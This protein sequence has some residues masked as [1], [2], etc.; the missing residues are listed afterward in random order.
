MRRRGWFATIVAAVGLV[1][2]GS[3]IGVDDFTGDDPAARLPETDGDTTSGGEG[4]GG[5]APGGTGGSAT[6]PELGWGRVI[7]GAGDDA[8][9]VAVSQG[10]DHWFAGYIDG[11]V[12]FGAG[13]VGAAGRQLF[14]AAVDDEGTLRFARASTRA[15]GMHV[16]LASVARRPEGA[17]LVGA[18][19][20]AFAL[21]GVSLPAPGGTDGLVVFVDGAGVAQ[22][23]TQLG[24]SGDQ[25]AW[26]V[27]TA[28][29][30]RSVVVGAFTG[31]LVAGGD[32]VTAAGAGDVFV[33]AFDA[34]G[35]L[36]WLRTMGDAGDQRATVVARDDA[37]WVV[38]G[39][40]AGT[41]SADGVAITSVGPGDGF[42]AR[43]DDAG[44]L[45]AASSFAR[46]GRVE[47]LRALAVPDGLWLGGAFKGTTSFGSTEVSTTAAVNDR[48]AFVARFDADLSVAEVEVWGEATG[49]EAVLAL[50]VNDGALLAAGE[51]SAQQLVLGGDTFTNAGGTDAF[52]FLLGAEGQTELAFTFGR[53]DTDRLVGASLG[54]STIVGAGTIGSSVAIDG[55]VFDGLGGSDI[56]V[57]AVAR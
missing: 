7:G 23:A 39:T 18:T 55:T 51:F 43:F 28:D 35:S 38:A 19:T 2:C 34:S 41:L 21:D 14:L 49:A 45:Q 50:D 15:G 4:G 8:V 42:V 17:V 57:F 12:D 5:G 47:P 11:E 37:G 30:G 32:T 1:G 44:T 27:A 53:N 46:G 10:D 29:D 6:A 16:D 40:F 22:A 31:Q 3:L 48:D 9:Q 20:Q 26:G 52:A 25:H 13:P 24:G 54:A 36:T 56:V 33:A